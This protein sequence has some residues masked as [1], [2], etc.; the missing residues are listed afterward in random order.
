MQS[1]MDVTVLQFFTCRTGRRKQ[2]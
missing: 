2:N 1:A